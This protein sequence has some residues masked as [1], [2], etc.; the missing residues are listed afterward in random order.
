M[1]QKTFYPRGAVIAASVLV[2]LLIAGVIVLAVVNGGTDTAGPAPTTTSAAPRPVALVPVDAP[3]AG[4]AD[5]AK[6]VKALP[7]TLVSNGK[8]LARAQIAAPAPKAALAWGPAESPVVLRCGLSR[9]PELTRTSSLRVISG[10]QWLPIGGDDAITWYAVD[11]AVTVALTIPQDAGTGPIQDV[12][13]TIGKTLA[14][15]PV[16]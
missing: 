14:A 9:P 7:R 16:F 12:S 13:S 15:K 6:L 8:P 4:G 10:V 3:D 11:R 2:G 1:S 5:C